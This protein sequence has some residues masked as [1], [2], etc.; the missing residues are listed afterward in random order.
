ML[1]SPILWEQ[2][3]ETSQ[4]SSSFLRGSIICWY[5]AS[6]YT[7]LFDF[8]ENPSRLMTM[9][10]KSVV[11]NQEQSSTGAMTRFISLYRNRSW[12]C[13]FIR[14]CAVVCVSSAINT[15]TE[16]MRDNE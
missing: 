13:S 4:C 16:N 5:P 6:G 1:Q 11:G 9:M 15:L 12:E 14:M 3:L 10:V 2:S 7:M 8:G